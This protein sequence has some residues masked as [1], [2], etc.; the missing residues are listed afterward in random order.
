MA[1]ICYYLDMTERSVQRV[2]QFWR[3]MGKDIDD[4]KH[5]GHPRLMTPE[6]MAF[7][8]GILSHSPDLYLDECAEE[9][10]YMHNIDPGL[11]TISRTLK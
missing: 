6:E 8:V 10:Y 11:S 4:P 9:L 3:Q 2:L 1:D 7:L 5:R